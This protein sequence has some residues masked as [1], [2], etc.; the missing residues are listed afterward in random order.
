MTVVA[1][2]FASSFAYT[3]PNAF[4][5]E[6]A[7]ATIAQRADEAQVQIVEPMASDLVVPVVARDS[8]SIT[9]K[10]PPPPP[11]PPRVSIPTSSFSRLVPSSSSA[12]LQWPV[13]AGTPMS[14]G[15]GPRNCS[16]CSSYHEGLDLN[17]PAGTPIWA[18]ADGVVLPSLGGG[19]SSLGQHVRIQHVIDG[20]V[21]VSLYAHMQAGSIAVSPGQTVVAGQAIGGMGCTGSCTGTHLHF[22]IHPGDG[23]AVDPL[24]W[25]NARIG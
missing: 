23:G 22:E 1:V 17:A 12:A 5:S 10:P 13:P 7:G 24:A 2:A 15:F 19:W 16:G 14:S 8:Y 21:I 6:Q 18:I 20:E 11:P 25:M 4:A 9:V 3:M